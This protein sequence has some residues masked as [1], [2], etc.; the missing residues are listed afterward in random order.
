MY[1]YIID[2]RH[3]VG[4]SIICRRHHRRRGDGGHVGVRYDMDAEV[5]TLG[6]GQVVV[7]VVLDVVPA[8][9]SHVT[10]RV[11]LGDDFIL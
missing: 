3:G 6:S 7:E 8:D 1:L 5:G 9:V 4:N 11:D 10:S 2:N